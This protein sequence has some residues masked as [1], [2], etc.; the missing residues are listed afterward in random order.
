MCVGGKKKAMI[1]GKDFEK[2]GLVKPVKTSKTVSA[3]PK[4]F[5]GSKEGQITLSGLL[6]CV[7]GL[8]KI[9]K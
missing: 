1:T 5:E 2:F 9:L 6:F 4:P 3:F 8:D 7:H